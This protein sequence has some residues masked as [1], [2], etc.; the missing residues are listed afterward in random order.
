MSH[1][2]CNL[3]YL[4]EK[5]CEMRK[6]LGGG[7]SGGKCMGENVWWKMYGGKCLGG[8]SAGGK[9]RGNLLGGGGGGSIKECR[10]PKINSYLLE[11]HKQL[12]FVIQSSGC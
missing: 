9:C 10:I 11:R 3:C 7:I 2:F 6:C 5:I 4:M 12:M 8:M 1:Q